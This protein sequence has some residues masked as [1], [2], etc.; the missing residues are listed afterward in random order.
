M[1]SSISPAFFTGCDGGSFYN[2]LG[3]AIAKYGVAS[4]LQSDRSKSDLTPYVQRNLPQSLQEPVNAHLKSP[5]KHKHSRFRRSNYFSLFSFFAMQGLVN[6]ERYGEQVSEQIFRNC[7]DVIVDDY[8]G[9][10]TV[11][12]Q[13]VGNDLLWSTEIELGSPTQTFRINIDTGSSDLLVF[14]AACESCALQNHTSFSYNTSSTFSK[15]ANSSFK[16]VYADNTNVVGF[17]GADTLQI[18]PAIQ[19]PNQLLGIATVVSDHWESLEVDGVLGLGSDTLSAFNASNN[20]GV[21]TR[22]VEDRVLKQPVIGIALVKNSRLNSSGEFSFGAI[23]DRW[24]R[25]GRHNLLWKD[26]TSRNFWG[27]GLNAIYVKGRN[28]LA[29]SQPPR[30]MID[31]GTSLTLVSVDTAAAIHKQIPGAVMDS[32]NGIWRLPCGVS[33]GPR[34]SPHSEEIRSSSQTQINNFD[35]VNQIKPAPSGT[36]FKALP[37]PSTHPAVTPNVFFQFSDGEMQFGIPAEDLAYQ[38]IPSSRSTSYYHGVKMCYSAIQSGSENFVVLG[39]T[40]IKNQ[41]IVLKR[42]IDGSRH[43]GLGARTDISPMF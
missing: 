31:T 7:R 22:L 10:A 16:E 21:F 25:G 23:Q 42:E 11:K 38:A 36:T 32:R 34:P 9:V 40:F 27:V 4:Y 12:T 30:A 33:S 28:V 37:N 39:D 43:V 20:K 2:Q 15:L 8:W 26:V 17:L 19:V 5:T 14:G 18:T 3:R 41:Y 13:S 29:E 6:V 24:I 1:T 35:A